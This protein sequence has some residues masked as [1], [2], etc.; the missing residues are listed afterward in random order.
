M[1][2]SHETSQEIRTLF[3]IPTHRELIHHSHHH[4]YQ[5]HGINGAIH[6]ETKK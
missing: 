2:V 1:Q 3:G 5:L 6:H 4:Y